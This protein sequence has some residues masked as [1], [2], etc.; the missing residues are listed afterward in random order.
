MKTKTVSDFTFNVCPSMLTLLG[1]DLV[2]FQLLRNFW[3]LQ[4][5]RHVFLGLFYI[6][7]N[8]VKKHFEL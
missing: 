8:L 4:V 6:K 5:S 7:F 1:R 3:T 2:D